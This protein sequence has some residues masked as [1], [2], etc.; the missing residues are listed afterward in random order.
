MPSVDRVQDA[1]AMFTERKAKG[2]THAMTTTEFLSRLHEYR[3]H[4]SGWLAL[5]PAHEDSNP[6]LSVTEKED[7]I[8]INCFAGCTP[9]SIVR[10]LGFELKDLFLEADNLRDSPDVKKRS[11]HSDRTGVVEAIYPYKNALGESLYEN[12]RYRPKDFR[13]RRREGDA[14]VYNLDGVERVPYGLPELI[15]VMKST[16]P[17]IWFTEGEKD[18]DNLRKL[19][20]ATTSFKSWKEEFNS[21]ITGCDAVMLSDHDE[22][23]FR[24]AVRAADLIGKVANTLKTIDLFPNEALGGQDIS[25]W[26]LLREGEDLDNDQIR[27]TLCDLVDLPPYSENVDRPLSD[28]FSVVDPEK[29]LDDIYLF[30]GRL[31]IVSK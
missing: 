25:D 9:D 8:L 20:F 13:L 3:R 5:C 27:Q 17:I 6:S 11:S 31:C 30:V 24:N 23:G 1:G 26:V 14:Y 29:L 22:A 18:A 16:R 21:Y 19:G 10:A 12:V 4:H 28:S 7:K 15:K 2:G